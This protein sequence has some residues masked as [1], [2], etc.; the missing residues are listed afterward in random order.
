MDLL[1]R[2]R[3]LKPELVHYA[4]SG[5][6]G[7]ELSAVLGRFY[8]G[9]QPQDEA[10][11]FLP[12]DYFVHQ[13]RLSGG[14][15]VVERFLEERPGLDETD[16]ALLL[17]WQEVVEGVFEVTG[18]D[19]P[20]V[21]LFNHVDE[22]TYRTLSNLGEEAFAP[23]EP[24]VFV[25]GRLIPLG[26]DWLI[27]ATPA[28]HPAGVRE[29]LI[30][31]AAHVALENPAAAFR[32]PGLLAA[33]R[34]AQA[35]QRRCFIAYFGADLVVLQGDEVADELGAYLGYQ[36]GQLGGDPAEP[37]VPAHVSAA[38]TVAL[39]FDEAEGL[40]Y[41]ADFGRLAEIFERPDLVIRREGRDLVTAYLKGEAVSPVPLV[42]L[43][44]RDHAKASAVFARLLG[45]SGFQWERSGQALLRT[46]KP[47][48]FAGP[49]LPTVVPRTRAVAAHLGG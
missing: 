14:E 9:G 43:A 46:H 7:R 32:N 26:H 15:T 39:I 19:G 8:A 49:R 25:V 24:G 21:R 35:E 48:H 37:E 10:N 45:R 36:A 4:T 2:A 28:V 20:A 44:E 1:A 18:F 5:R 34:H 23:L 13:H 47:G 22:L 33:A 31:T 3:E 40:G 27:S 41:Y 16:R 29:T 42:R 12:V 38:G 6:F 17:S 11:A 30:A